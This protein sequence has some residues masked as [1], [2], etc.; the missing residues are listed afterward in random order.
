MDDEICEP[1]SVWQ[2]ESE[3]ILTVWLAETPSTLKVGCLTVF[4]EEIGDTRVTVEGAVTIEP[5]TTTPF[6]DTQ[7]CS[8]G[9]KS[10]VSLRNPLD[11]NL[12]RTHT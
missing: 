12:I 7:D 10:K 1:T 3:N 2:L 11:V 5:V 4:G 6:S 8:M 9:I